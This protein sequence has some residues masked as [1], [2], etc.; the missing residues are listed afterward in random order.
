MLAVIVPVYRA[1]LDAHEL[2]AWESIT[3]KLRRHE[4]IWIGPDALRRESFY[5]SSGFKFAPFVDSHFASRRSYSQLLTS[6]HFYLTF[7]KYSHIL[8]AQLDSLIVSDNVQPWLDSEF[9][10]VGAPLRAG[11][12][13]TPGA[14]FGPG[15]N[16][17]LSLRR[18]EAA[19]RVL[20]SPQKRRI[21]LGQAYAMES[22]PVRRVVRTVRDGMLFNYSS[23][24]G[25]LRRPRINE[26]LY[27]SHIVPRT[28]PWFSVPCPSVASRFATDA[29][30]GWPHEHYRQLG[31]LIGIHAFQKL[32]TSLV[33]EMRDA[34]G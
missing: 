28:N 14:D 7:A 17:G 16:G 18:V 22:S 15:L 13:L 11:Y 20:A 25:R 5:R 27:W 30:N 12:G 31:G 29:S 21:P 6:S 19:L 1:I 2:V 24:G 26:D 3:S 4:I 8:I 33:E 9:D 23:R 34:S 32:P 10:F